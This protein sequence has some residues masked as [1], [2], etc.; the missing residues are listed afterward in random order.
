M[1]ESLRGGLIGCGFFAQNHLN[2]WAD[3]EGA[4][5][6]AVCDRDRAKAEAAAA[7]FGIP[8]VYDDAEAMFASERLDYVDIATTMPTHRPLVELAARH[9]VPTICQKPFAPTLP[10]CVAMVEACEGAGVPLMVHE[11]FRFQTPL[12]A[13]AEVVRSGRI[14]EIFFGRVSWRNAFDVFKG[15]PYLAEEERFAILDVGVHVLDVARV[16]MGEIDRLSCVTNSVHP[17][18]KGEDSC[19]ILTRHANG[20]A[21]FVDVSYASKLDPDPFPQTLVELD[22]AAGSIRLSVGYELKVVDAEGT[23]CR[24]VRPALLPWAQTPWHGPQESVLNTQRHFIESLRAG[25]E[26]ATSGRDNLK[27]FAACEAAYESAETGATVVPQ[28]R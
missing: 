26:P 9:K 27:T 21:G 13:V 17:G 24:N 14:G 4:G 16:L 3:V 23:E 1:S 12:L 10:D 25:R 28:F 20:A 22:G 11:N 19:A 18:I 8:A 15:Q 7:K 6:V 2:A 5:L